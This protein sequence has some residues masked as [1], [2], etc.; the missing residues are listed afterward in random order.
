MIQYIKIPVDATT[1]A[2]EI[3]CPMCNS[4]HIISVDTDGLKAYENGALVQQAFP[5]LDTYAREMII[6]GICP[7][8]WDE[9]DRQ[10]LDEYYDDEEEEDFEEEEPTTI[11]IEDDE[12]FTMD[13]ED[14]FAKVLGLKVD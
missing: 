8:C 1:T 14:F 12:Y 2:L 10:W 11:E 13:L 9:M 3:T 5:N 6:S 4:T 7:L